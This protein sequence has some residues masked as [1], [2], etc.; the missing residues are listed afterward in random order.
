MA[1]SITMQVRY[2]E[3]INSNTEELQ[4]LKQDMATVEEMLHSHHE[5]IT[6]TLHQVAADVTAV[7]AKLIAV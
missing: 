1:N 4:L 7:H 6:T 2:K 5:Y 3:T